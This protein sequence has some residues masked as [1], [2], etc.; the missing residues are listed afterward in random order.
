MI[1]CGKHTN[2]N[3]LLI[4]QIYLTGGVSPFKLFELQFPYALTTGYVRRGQWAYKAKE[5]AR[6]I[7]LHSHNI[8]SC[9]M[10]FQPENMRS[11]MVRNVSDNL[12]LDLFRMCREYSICQNAGSDMVQGDEGHIN[13]WMLIDWNFH[14]CQQWAIITTNIQRVIRCQHLLYNQRKS[15]LH[16]IGTHTIVWK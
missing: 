12:F 1:K 2:T 16:T 11:V 5:S 13:F 15:T 9:F 4:S 7:V 14:H 3:V 6:E 10:S 8:Y